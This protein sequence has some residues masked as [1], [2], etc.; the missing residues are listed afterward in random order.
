MKR[1]PPRWSIRLLRLLLKQEYLEEIEGDLQEV[2][3]NDI[4]NYTY[5]K[6][7]RLYILEVAKLM[8]I[9]L[10]KRVRV[11]SNA[12]FMMNFRRHFTFAI[13][14]LLK[15]KTHTAINLVG[16]SI[17]LSLGM[18]ILFYVMDELSYDQFHAK[19]DR[20]YKVVTGNKN[21]GIETNAWPIGHLLKT[22]FPEVEEIVYTT[23]SPSHYKLNIDG[24]RYE[25]DIH[26]ASEGFL[27]VFS[28]PLVSGSASGLLAEPNSIVITQS[29][30]DMY[31]DGAAIGKSITLQDS[32]NFTITGVLADLPSNSHIQFD[33]LLS[34]NH[35]IK[36]SGFKYSEGWG[37]FNVRNYMLLKE[38]VNVE[39]FQSKISG[40][41]HEHV[42]DWLQKMGMDFTVN[43][44]PVTDIYL[45]EIFHNG[46]GPK[47]SMRRVK[48]VAWIAVF[49]LLL[50]CINFINLSTARSLHRMKEVAVK[51]LM[52]SNRT[53]IIIQ[54]I[55]EAALLVILSLLL[56][57]ILIQFALPFFNEVLS[58]SYGLWQFVDWQFGLGVLALVICCIFLA[59]FYPA[60]VLS[61]FKP[62][63]AIKGE[64]LKTQTGL[65]TRK[66]LIIFQYFV[67]SGLI[68][69]TLL[70]IN[71]IDY[72]KGTNP[73][74]DKDQIL[75]I[76]A[77]NTP[78]NGARTVLK[79]TIETISGVKVVS[80][81]NSLPGRPGWLGQWAYPSEVSDDHVDTEYL[82]IDEDYLQTLGLELLA[83]ENFDLAKPADLDNGLII[84]E[85]CLKAMGWLDPFDAIGREI[86]SP[87]QHPAGKVIGVVKDYH[88]LGLQNKIWPM[89][90]DYKSDQYGRYLAIKYD[91]K[92]TYE[93]VKQLKK[94][95]QMTYAN[96]ELDYFFLDVDFD[97]QYRKESQLASVLSV[98][99]IVIMIVSIIGLIGLVSFVAISKTKEIGVRKVLGASVFQIIFGL[100]KDFL[101]L[102]LIGNILVV[103]FIWHFG[104]EWL[105]D[106]AYHTNINPLIFLIALV[107]SLLLTLTVV[108]LVTYR[109]ALRNPANSLKYE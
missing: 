109:S 4:N 26:Y 21:G 108:S 50:A 71:Q 103:P 2:F 65:G 84:N 78:N 87:S 18:L 56:S 91:S 34:F 105:N 22:N 76:N 43:L 74:F 17:G 10:V 59:G 98:F 41:Y 80:H 107:S 45:G 101:W 7:R 77:T 54:F 1:T 82:A 61:R 55:I 29:M 33:A 30:E 75:V 3:E 20:I 69:A 57:V 79:E 8:R 36:R 9:N 70:V 63:Q 85:S 72:M 68:I 27:E 64:I 49:L 6:A 23:K 13:R 67:S 42:G 100:S 89:A 24:K 95:W 48:T 106:F 15:F 39:N 52:G 46:F 73:G 97:R 31:F 96:Y 90:M 25:L 60:L 51:K 5:K 88:G 86:F 83:G 99:A 12:N 93:L 92:H 40:M 38:G 11:L 32:L 44:I 104:N 94:S 35:Y 81:T 19:K 28:F 102:V 58:K 37:N 16:L 53:T 66:S 47:S 62:I 14:N